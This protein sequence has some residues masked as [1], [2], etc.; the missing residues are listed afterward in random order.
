MRSTRTRRSVPALV[1]AGAIV[2][3]AC[4]GSDGDATDAAPAAG[5]ENEGA[6]ALPAVE[7]PVESGDVDGGVPVSELLPTQVDLIGETVVAEAEI[8]SNLLPPVVLDDLT[9]GRKVNFRN[10][11]PQEKPILLWMYAPH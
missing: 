5:V 10:L 9:T 6:D 11:V 4:G 3:A 2:L 1:A 7:E 8:E